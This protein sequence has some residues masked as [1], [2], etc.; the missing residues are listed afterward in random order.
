MVK[1]QLTDKYSNSTNTSTSS[2]STNTNSTNT[3]I[4]IHSIFNHLAEPPLDRQMPVFTGKYFP[5]TGKK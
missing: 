3:V 4:V 1:G 2:N 5:C